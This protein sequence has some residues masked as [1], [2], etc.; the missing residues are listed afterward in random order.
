M[1]ILLLF[2]AHSKYFHPKHTYCYIFHIANQ[3]IISI[4]CIYSYSSVTNSDLCV[5]FVHIL[6]TITKKM[7][8]FI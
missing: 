7:S 2:S 3:I 8:S 6:Y 4:F 5:Y 1:L